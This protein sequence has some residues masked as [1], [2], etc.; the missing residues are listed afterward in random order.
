MT[1]L[2]WIA[3]SLTAYGLG[4]AL[5]VAVLDGRHHPIVTLFRRHGGR[6]AR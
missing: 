6:H 3:Y 5:M 4:A 2:A 1:V